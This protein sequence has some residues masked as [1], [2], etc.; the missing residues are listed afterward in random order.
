MEYLNYI[1][2][3]ISTILISIIIYFLQNEKDQK[4]LSNITMSKI[5]L[6]SMV[7]G[8]AIYIYMNKSSIH[9]EPIMEGNFFD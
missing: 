1:V 8:I 2:P 5:I 4:K 7:G 6:P 3:V 9:N